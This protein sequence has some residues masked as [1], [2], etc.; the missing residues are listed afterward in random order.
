MYVFISYSSQNKKLAESF[1]ILFNKNGIE[2]WMAPGDIPIGSTYTSEINRAIKNSS[3]F[4]L[5][6]SESAQKSQWVLR[7]TERA[8]SAGKPIFTILL[9]DVEMNDDFEF[10]LRTSQLITLKKNDES[11]VKQLIES[12]KTILCLSENVKAP[13]KYVVDKNVFIQTLQL[14]HMLGRMEFLWDT[15]FNVLKEEEKKPLMI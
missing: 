4:V 2:T 13:E 14:G 9:N 11:K 6:F 12:M 1:K 7:E 15:K 8:V 5:L 3:A 10:M